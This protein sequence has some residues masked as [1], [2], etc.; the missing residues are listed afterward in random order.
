[1]TSASDELKQGLIYQQAGRTREA[2]EAFVRATLA[3]PSH[4]EAWCRLAAAQ[5]ALLAWPAA[6]AAY[7]QALV[8]KPDFAEVL[9]NLATVYL[10][11][12]E[13]AAAQR[14]FLRALEIKPGFP[15]AWNGL[16]VAQKALLDLPAAE[17]SFRRALSVRPVYPQAHYNLANTVQL[18]ERWGEAIDL[19]RAV[20]QQSPNA[21]DA[22]H[23]LG[24]ALAGA[25]DYDSAIQTL[26]RVLLLKPDH[27]EAWNQLGNTYLKLGQRIRAREAL[28]RAIAVRPTF[29][30]ALCNLGNVYLSGN[31]PA[32]ALSFY[33]RASELKPDFAPADFNASIAHLVRGE[34]REGFQKY[35]QR[36]QSEQKKFFRTF[37]QPLWTGRESLAGKTILIHCEQ[38]LGDTLQFIR[39]VPFLVERG[40]RVLLEVQPPLL[41]LLH[42]FPGT[43]GV[44]AKHG[45]TMNFDFHCPI[46][47]LPRA[48]ETDLG[49]IPAAVPY[50]KAPPRAAE[51][52]KK[53][54]SAKDRLRIGLVVSGNPKHKN[55]R[56]RSIPLEKFAP[57]FKALK[58]DWFLVQKELGGADLA[59]AGKMTEL[60]NCG[61]EL[62]DFADTAGLLSQLDHILSVDT[63]V[64]H[65]AGA[66]GK[67]VS[68][69]L[70]FAPDWRWML[71]R[72]DSP[73]YPTMKL[74]RQ[75][76]P[77]DW[78]T[79]LAKVVAELSKR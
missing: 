45:A 11:Q 10:Q 23:N 17:A 16:G 46:L 71:E 37:S 13:Y 47:S 40:A 55:D 77:G 76:V 6:A 3:D 36:W 5:E 21:V 59:T 2:S 43:A 26:Q 31:D 14:R 29:L 22:L 70:P 8:L 75:V 39:Y 65:L 9:C 60:R 50:L 61:P 32:R 27:A 33:A 67:P 25:E 44:Y 7:E 19:Y 68:L 54:L 38:G 79:P 56:N 58:A 62:K 42:D 49:Q 57:L 28:E 35:E 20:L 12:Q 52:W 18:L 78:D 4:L 30:E 66:M 72:E 51:A 53:K 69:L 24:C 74:F 41:P 73:W 48:F 34:L 15:E 1:M 63:S 64:A